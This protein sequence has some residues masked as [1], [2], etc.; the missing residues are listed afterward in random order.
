MANKHST[1]KNTSG[2]NQPPLYEVKDLVSDK[3]LKFPTFDPSGSYSPHIPSQSTHDPT[4]TSS[5]ETPYPNQDSSMN[6][7]IC[8]VRPEEPIYCFP[9]N[10][11]DQLHR[12]T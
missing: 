6:E 11:V 4:Y 7:E 8:G 1:R 9:N 3:P 5:L 10:K 12:H 2:P